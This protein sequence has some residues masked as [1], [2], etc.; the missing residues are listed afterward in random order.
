VEGKITNIYPTP[1]ARE[2]NPKMQ[3][4]LK[5]FNEQYAR[6]FGREESTRLVQTVAR[7]ADKLDL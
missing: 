7:A 4:C 2:L 1:K 6:F 5:Q 3:A